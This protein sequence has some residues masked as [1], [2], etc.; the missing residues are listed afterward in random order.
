MNLRRLGVGG[1][2]LVLGFFPGRATGQERPYRSGW[3]IESGGGTGTIRV[4]CSNCADITSVYGGSA[5]NRLGHSLSR[6]VLMGVEFFTLLKGTYVLGPQDSVAMSNESIT[7]IVMWY[8][9]KSGLFL[10]GGTGLAYGEF[11]LTA[12]TNSPVLARGFGSSLTFGAGFD[13]PVFKWLSITANFGTYFTA[14]GDFTVGTEFRDDAV[15]TMYNA[16]FAVTIR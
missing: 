15:A 4:G 1:V 10:K 14:L 3:W 13:I 16:N 12:E 6:S 7:A 2:A 11:T 5:Y 8:P 9:W